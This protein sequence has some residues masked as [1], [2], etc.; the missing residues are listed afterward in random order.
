MTSVKWIMLY[1]H[2]LNVLL[3]LSISISVPYIFH[4]TY[5]GLAL[6]FINFPELQVYIVT[7]LFGYPSMQHPAILQ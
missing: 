1:C 5:S 3:D 4:P 6:G 2:V 7:S